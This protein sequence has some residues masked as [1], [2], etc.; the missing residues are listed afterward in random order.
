MHLCGD[1]KVAREELLEVERRSAPVLGMAWNISA[2]QVNM[3]I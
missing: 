1:G 3:F 2:R